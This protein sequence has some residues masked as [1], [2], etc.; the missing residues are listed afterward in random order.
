MSDESPHSASST[1]PHRGEVTVSR[2]EHRP[3]AR[4]LG[5]T[6]FSL[7][8][9]PGVLTMF[10]GGFFGTR[11]NLNHRRENNLK[12]LKTINNIHKN[13][14]KTPLTTLLNTIKNK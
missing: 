7:T 11:N 2:K 6:A 1:T 14:I 9:L 12:Q 3:L 13:T 4:V 5:W 10:F 8:L